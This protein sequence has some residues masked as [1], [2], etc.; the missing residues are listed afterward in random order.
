MSLIGKE[1]QKVSTAT[2]T[3]APCILGIDCEERVLQG[4]KRVLVSF[5]IGALQSEDMK[6]VFDLTDLS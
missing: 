5:G 6:Q 1:W 3:E 4:P 2:S